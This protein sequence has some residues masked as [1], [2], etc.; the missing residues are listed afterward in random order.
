MLG[1]LNND[2]VNFIIHMSFKKKVTS[3]NG[4]V[5]QIKWV[6]MEL[7]DNLEKFH[8]DKHIKDIRYTRRYFKIVYTYSCVDQ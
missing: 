2:W 8:I 3:N 7:Y 6:P 4:R 5:R 1:I